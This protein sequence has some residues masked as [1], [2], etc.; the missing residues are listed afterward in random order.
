MATNGQKMT[1]SVYRMSRQAAAEWDD[2]LRS[3]A[4]AAERLCV[5]PRTLER[6]ELE[7]SIPP[8]D[9]VRIM[10]DVYHA[11]ELPYW[12]CA[13]A[14]PIGRVCVPE[15]KQ[16]PLERI[17]LQLGAVVRAVRPAVE[18][19]QDIACDGVVDDDEVPRMQ[20]AIQSILALKPV[21]AEAE[22]WAQKYLGGDRSGT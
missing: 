12:Y 11:P 1:K 9:I 17:A 10:A 4:G 14:C 3:I 7:T 5:D 6:Y 13:N 20:Q 8:S 21:I 2:S 16:H 18:E 22:V 19:L 15:I